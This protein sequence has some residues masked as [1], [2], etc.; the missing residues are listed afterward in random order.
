VEKTLLERTIKTREGQK[1][2]GRVRMQELRG[3]DVSVPGR[4]GADL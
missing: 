1:T 2:R 3:G 4:N